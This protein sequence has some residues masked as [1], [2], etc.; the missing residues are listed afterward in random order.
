MPGYTGF[1]RQNIH[2]LPQ[3]EPFLPFDNPTFGN[4]AFEETAYRVLIARLSPWA[5]RLGM[6]LPR[7][8]RRGIRRGALAA[9]RRGTGSR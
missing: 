1:F 5:V 8:L 2:R 9:F 4:P 3:A 7:P 6:V